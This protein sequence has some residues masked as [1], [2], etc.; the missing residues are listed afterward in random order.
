VLFSIAYQPRL[1]LANNSDQLL[2]RLIC[3]LPKDPNAPWHSLDDAYHA[4]LWDILPQETSISGIGHDD[5]VILDGCKAAN[6][7]WKSFAPVAHAR[8]F[9]WKR[10]L[11]LN[12][13]HVSGYAFWTSIVLLVVMPAIGIPL[14]I[15]SIIFIGISP[16][17]LRVMYL[18]KFWGT[19]GWFFGFEGY[20]DIDTIERQIFGA[21]LGRMKWSAY[22]SPLS[23]HHMNVH[24][25][26]VPD[27]PCSDPDIAA[28]VE[29]A[30]YAQPGE[31]RIFTLV[32][33]G[34]Y[35]LDS[36]RYLTDPLVLGSMTATLFLA[37]RPPVCFLL[38]G[39]EGGMK[40]AIGCSYDW[41]NATL[42]RET[43]LRMETPIDDR[44]SRIPRVKIGFNRPLHPYRNLEDVGEAEG[45]RVD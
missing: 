12:L 19:Q 6:V 17:L 8:V 29:R 5:T 21:R 15:Y 27:D 18:G 2:E 33:T 4:K 14:F 39:S 44:M 37:A 13:L 26:C 31:Q 43:V 34:K 40:R 23:R 7:R 10:W 16:W 3:I 38:A 11:S 25:E 24:G 35:G 36:T 20:M 22:S 42:Y 9:S 1:S 41:T 32:D 30:K 45:K 28:L